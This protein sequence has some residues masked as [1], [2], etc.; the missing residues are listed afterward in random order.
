MAWTEDWNF[1]DDIINLAAEKSKSASSPLRYMNKLLLSLN[2]KNIHDL[3]KAKEEL[4]HVQVETTQ[5][6]NLSKDF[7]QREYTKEELNALF[8]SLDDIEV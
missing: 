3:E 6:Y 2:A 5:N 8:D 7:S 4:S 1:S